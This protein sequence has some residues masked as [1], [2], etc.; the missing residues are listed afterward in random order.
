KR[1]KRDYKKRSPL[2]S[3]DDYEINA[4]RLLEVSKGNEKLVNEVFEMVTSHQ[5]GEEKWTSGFLGIQVFISRKKDT[6]EGKVSEWIHVVF[7]HGYAVTLIAGRIGHTD[8]TYKQ[9]MD[10]SLLY[11]MANTM[12]NG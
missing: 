5:K 9:Y 12:K 2:S 8:W 7:D 3:Y 10:K 6:I 11:S 1:M 4:E